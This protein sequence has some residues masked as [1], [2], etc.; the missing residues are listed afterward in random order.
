[1]SPSCIYNFSARLVVLLGAAHGLGWMHFKA[2]YK[3][4][5]SVFFLLLHTYWARILS[6]HHWKFDSPMYNGWDLSTSKKPTSSPL[7]L[8]NLQNRTEAGHYG[9]P[10]CCTAFPWSWT[11][12]QPGGM[13]GVMVENELL[14]PCNVLWKKKVIW[15][16]QYWFL[17]SFLHGFGV[18]GD[19][20]DYCIPLWAAF[21]QNLEA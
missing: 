21:Y 17:L 19:C 16:L 2:I 4:L 12:F 13:K 7:H 9:L 1:M 8:L 20:L 14:W 5:W 11:E 15:G 3:S 18:L 10:S 6:L